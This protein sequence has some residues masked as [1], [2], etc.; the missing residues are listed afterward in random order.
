MDM[1]FDREPQETC[2]ED[3]GRSAGYGNV[4]VLQYLAASLSWLEPPGHG[5][6]DTVSSLLFLQLPLC[7]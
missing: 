4:R 2:G 1:F 5:Y 6:R 3:R 7:G